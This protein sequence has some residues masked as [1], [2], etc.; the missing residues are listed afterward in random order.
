MKYLSL[1]RAFTF[2]NIE[3]FNKLY[4]QRYNS[5]ATIKLFLKIHDY[6]SFIFF[7]NELNILVNSIRILDKKIENIFS[8]L[9]NVAKNQYTKKSMIDEIEFN[10]SIEG[11]ISTRKEINEI[12]E[13]IK[14]KNNKQKRLQGIINKY[15]MLANQENIKLESAED[16][17]IIYDEMLYEEIRQSNENNLPDGKLFRKDIVNVTTTTGKVIHTGIVPEEKIISSINEAIKILNNENY[18]ALIRVALFHYIFAYIHPFYDGNGRINRFISS[19]ILSKN[20]ISIIG[21]RLS[22]TIKENLSDYYDAFKNTND[23]RNKGDITLFVIEFLKI[24]LKA[25]EKTELY[26]LNK[27][28]SLNRYNELI[29]NKN[30]NQKLSNLL[31]ILVQ[32]EM[33]SEFGLSITELS[34]VSELSPNTIRNKLKILK[35]KNLIKEINVGKRIYYSA[36]LENLE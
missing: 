5:E 9:P 14:L 23:I 31:Y 11:V 13:D 12:I 30:L 6:T 22:L 17:R 3:E 34:T 19:Y 20:Y 29:S 1:Y 2:Y 36:N 10:N 18:D 24:I 21:Y 35:G 25:Y 33:F 16:I 15:I 4:E 32:V 7:P 27:L 26:A 8:Q 28:K